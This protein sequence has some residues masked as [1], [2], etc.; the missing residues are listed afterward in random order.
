MNDQSAGQA[1][2]PR[3]AYLDHT[4][5]RART[6]AEQ[7][8][9]RY[10]TLEH[11]L[12]ALLDDPDAAKLLRA[13][14]AD[15]AVIHSAISDAVNNRMASLVATGNRPPGFSSKFDS[16]FVGAAEDA[17]SAGRREVDGALT[18]IAVAKDAES[19]AS[20]ILTANGFD[21]EA[22]LQTL[23]TPPEPEQQR[24]AQANAATQPKQ[25]ANLA[26]VE[27]PV[28]NAAQGQNQKPAG[29]ATA[30][31]P[32]HPQ[33]AGAAPAGESMEDM[34]ASVRGILEAEERKDQQ[35]LVMD[36][37]PPQRPQRAGP[38][39]PVK[40]PSG[41]AAAAAA[42]FAERS[43]PA[44]DLETPPRTEKRAAQPRS[45]QRGKFGALA[46]LPKLLEHIPRKAKAGVPL[47]I[48]VQL[49]KEDAALIFGGALRRAQPQKA[50]AAEAVCRAVTLRL[51][52]PDGGFFIEGLAP[53]TQWILDRPSFM[54]EEAFGAWAWTASP[55]ASGSCT[56]SLTLSARD[57]DANGLASDI[58]LPEQAIK[59]QVSGAFWRRAGRFFRA[60]LLFLAGSG[61]GVAAYHALKIAGKIPH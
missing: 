58:N 54:G 60:A 57:I 18:L 20:A 9:H 25:A 35:P 42:G 36:V 10:V 40:T 52:S 26:R 19:K 14:G 21:A 46:L 2:L 37:A 1:D 47:A 28:R 17:C 56:L 34:L 27:A 8:S 5:R 50:A 41:A 23:I 11:L 48:K 59:V 12:L 45:A 7:R 13:A 4:L 55:I 38:V 16:L 24:A 51:S 3:T 30:R 49:S 44:F 53:E 33:P 29:G 39:R 15:V 31:A 61:L 22:A 32:A 6:A 43:A